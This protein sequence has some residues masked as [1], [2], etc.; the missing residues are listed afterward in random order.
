MPSTMG[1]AGTAGIHGSNG[2]NG[3][4]RNHRMPAIPPNPTIPQS[5]GP[6]RACD[7]CHKRKIKCVTQ[8]TK[9]PCKNCVSAKLQCTYLSVPLKKGPKGTHAKVLNTIREEQARPNVLPP[10]SVDEHGRPAR[11]PR[12]L[13]R[14]MM[15]SCLAFLDNVHYLYPFVP[16]HDIRSLSQTVDT[17]LDAYCTITA[18]CA[19]LLI[20]ARMPLDPNLIERQEYRAA[21]SLEYGELLLEESMRIRRGLDD[22]L[23]KPSYS[24][25]LTSWLYYGCHYG[26][27]KESD[28][29]KVLQE[30]ITQ[31]YLLGFQKDDTFEA[32]MP[33]GWMSRVVPQRTFFWSLFMQERAHGLRR[34][35]PIRLAPSMLPPALD[36][37][38]DLNGPERRAQLVLLELHQPFQ[39]FDEHLVNWCNNG[40]TPERETIVAMQQRLAG[41]ILSEHPMCPEPMTANLRITQLWLHI[42]L[43]RLCHER[44]LV[45]SVTEEPCLQFQYPIDVSSRVFSVVNHVSPRSLKLLGAELVAKLFDIACCVIKV[46]A[47]HPAYREHV[48]DVADFCQL[49]SNLQEGNAVY[50][51]R[52]QAKIDDHWP[53]LIQHPH[54]PEVTHTMH[55]GVIQVPGFPSQAIVPSNGAQGFYDPY[56]TATSSYSLPELHQHMGI[57]AVPQQFSSAESAHQAFVGVQPTMY[58]PSSAFRVAVTEAGMPGGGYGHSSWM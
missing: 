44:G 10:L 40:K 57:T 29:W 55:N 20:Q 41:T 50:H 24:T 38:I 11:S 3:R 21:T 13:P 52:L 47:G 16:M 9:P 25:I 18:L 56:P 45:P 2:S 43:W 23:V 34:R 48:H 39:P 54:Q 5:A 15:D 4:K 28:A 8:G 14:A 26:L 17:S 22:C 35:F 37:W 49:L 19:N 7:S 1:T 53:G 32:P 36:N 31:A 51:R 42:M 6:K 12:V 58:S 30:A 46:I 27:N 33:P